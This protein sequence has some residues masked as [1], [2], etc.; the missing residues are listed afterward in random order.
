M[1]PGGVG[2]G[3]VRVSYGP[4]AWAI[5]G[6]VGLMAYGLG[7]SVNRVQEPNRTEIFGS[8]ELG[9]EQRTEIVGFGSF[10]FGTRL[11]RFGPRFSVKFAQ[12]EH[13]PDVPNL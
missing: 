12:P 9:T 3:W 2:L 4:T 6:F 11:I 8:S 7:S 1:A 10:G 5:L 13:R